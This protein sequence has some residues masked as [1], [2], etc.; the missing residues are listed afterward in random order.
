MVERWSRQMETPF[1]ELPLEEQ[2][3]DFIEADKILAVFKKYEELIEARAI[4]KFT[5]ELIAGSIKPH[6]GEQLMP[7]QKLPDGAIPHYLEFN[8]GSVAEG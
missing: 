2:K 6:I 3:S 5:Q 1:S 4:S 7:M 8:Y